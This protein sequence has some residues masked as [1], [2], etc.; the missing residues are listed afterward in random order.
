MRPLIYTTV[1]GK[2]WYYYGNRLIN[3][4]RESGYNGDILAICD[5]GY[6]PPEGVKRFAFNLD[7]QDVVDDRPATSRIWMTRYYIDRLGFDDYTDYLYLDAD[8]VVMPGREIDGTCDLFAKGNWFTRD[9]GKME[10]EEECWWN[11]FGKAMPPEL[12]TEHPEWFN[13][14]SGT[15][16]IDRH[17]LAE[18]CD[19]VRKVY[20]SVPDLVTD[21]AALNG[22]LRMHAKI[23]WNVYRDFLIGFINSWDYDLAA[24]IQCWIA[25]ELGAMKGMNY[26]WRLFQ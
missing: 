16:K 21:Q 12:V 25:H 23:E 8:C 6:S 11:Y 20:R 26:Q 17:D 5:T 14:N 3:S 18:F 9:R 15:F 2:E 7:K 10:P 24:R 1:Y 22:Y 19:G 4:I 13:I